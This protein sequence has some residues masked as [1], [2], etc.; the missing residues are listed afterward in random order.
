MRSLSAVTMIAALTITMVLASSA[1]AQRDVA[2]DINGDGGGDLLVGVPLEGVAGVSEA[3]SVN[4]ILSNGNRLATKG[5][6]GLTAGALGLPT[7]RDD[8]FGAA[9][10]LG[11][12]DG[13][14][15][16]DAIIGTSG[17][18]IAGV[19]AAGSIQVVPGSRRGLVTDAARSYA[20][21]LDVSNLTPRPDARFGSTIV[22]GDFN[23]D[24]IDD[25]AVAAPFDTIDGQTH[26][27]SVT[28]ISGSPLGLQPATAAV[29]SQAGDAAGSPEAGDNFGWALSVGDFDGDGHDDLAIGVPGEDGGATVNAGAVNVFYGSTAGITTERNRS[30]SQR[31]SIKEVP[32]A[33][34]LFGFSVAAAD[35]DCDG[36]D[37]LAVGVPNEGVR[38]IQLAGYVNVIPGSASGLRKGGNTKLSQNGKRVA[39]ALDHNQFG[40]SLAGGDFDGDGCGDLAIGAHT[41]DI[42]G[43]SRS[44]CS[45]NPEC[46]FE[47]GAVV[48]VYGA[49]RWPSTGGTDRFTQKGPVPG[50]PQAKDFFGRTLAVVD[51]NGDGR[52]ELVVGAPR[53]DLRGKRNAGTATVL[54]GTRD[55]L[56]A[57][58]SYLLSQAGSMAG[59]PERGDQFASALFAGGS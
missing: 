16:A 4:A 38:G 24:G 12:V 45:V 9:V 35:V 56:S 49:K 26:A 20:P 51:A 37:D 36:R 53:E 59:T 2:Q 8:H 47:A 31:G 14:G 34:D 11:D 17:A 29:L 57:S 48:V 33:G 1:A 21:G 46:I 15:F 18:A 6:E 41:T 30:F 25:V 13:D 27:G 10:A 39:G 43:D 52:D 40:A 42:G 5:N 7:V 32:E 55:G 22:V 23:R 19:D 28:V 54:R 44:V 3:G 58:R 50:A